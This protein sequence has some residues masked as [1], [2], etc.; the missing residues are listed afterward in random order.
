MGRQ[1]L[2]LLRAAG[3]P[4]CGTAQ[5]AELAVILISFA[6]FATSLTF[7]TGSHHV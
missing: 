3:S 4:A 7:T 2:I 1:S 6:T 5:E